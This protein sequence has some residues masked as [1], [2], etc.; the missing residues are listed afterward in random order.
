MTFSEWYAAN[1]EP[2]MIQNANQLPDPEQRKIVL[3]AARDSMAACWNAALRSSPRDGETVN[4]EEI[5][6]MEFPTV[7][8]MLGRKQFFDVFREIA[9]QLAEQNQLTREGQRAA[10]Q[11]DAITAELMGKSVGT[12]TEFVDTQTTPTPQPP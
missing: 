10:K 9:A 12:L 7:R 8:S 4:A 3:Q 11:R 2:A 1:V 5:R 6:A